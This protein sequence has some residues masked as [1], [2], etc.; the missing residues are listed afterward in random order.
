MLEMR[1]FISYFVWH[2]RDAQLVYNE[3][4]LFEDRFV[5][6]RGPLEVRL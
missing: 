3:E 4:P 2:F 1:L 5:A 6:R